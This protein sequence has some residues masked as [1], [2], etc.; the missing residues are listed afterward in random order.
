MSLRSLV[1][2]STRA[3]VLENTVKIQT[4]RFGTLS[5]MNSFNNT[6]VNM[7][8]FQIPSWLEAFLWAA[9]KKKTSHSKKRMRASNKGLQQKEN[10]TTC[11]V[12]GS[13]KMMHHLCGHCY[14]DIKKKAKLEVA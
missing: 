11:P 12:C 3:S 13:H 14:S 6:A 9:P 4:S 8:T 1:R 5:L 7:N 10:I 2:F